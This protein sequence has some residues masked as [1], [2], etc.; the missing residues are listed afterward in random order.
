[1]S[2]IK[3]NIVAQIQDNEYP[4]DQMKKQIGQVFTPLKWAE[5][6]LN[7]WNIFEAWLD[8]AHICD[9]TAGQGAFPLAMLHIARQKG[10]PIT[11]ERLSRLSLIEIVPSHLERFMRKRQARVWR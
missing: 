9:P 2:I 11:A 1:M 3:L 4:L 10:I 8:G 7:K 5:W 6:L